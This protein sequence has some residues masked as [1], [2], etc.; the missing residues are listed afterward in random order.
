MLITA[1]HP[2]KR[3]RSRALG[4]YLKSEEISYSFS[5]AYAIP[6]NGYREIFN[7]SLFDIIKAML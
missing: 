2:D 3:R 7:F 4:K 6:S 1:V 5:P